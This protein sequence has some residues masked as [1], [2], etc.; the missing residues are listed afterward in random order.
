[1]TQTVILRGET[2]RQLAHRLIDRAPPNYIVKIGEPTRTQDQNNKLWA[3]LTDVSR[4]KPEGRRH[5]PD[6]WKALFMQAC[7]H[8]QQFEIGLN[9]QPFPMGFRS[10]RLTVKQMNDLI[11][12]IY[13]YGAR[14]CVQWSDEAAAPTT[15]AD[16]AAAWRTNPMTAG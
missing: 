4:A 5:V 11:E 7:G 15:D 14:H 9:G 6:V 2:Q 3:M 13:E 16:E 12:C 10:S 1:M 8:A